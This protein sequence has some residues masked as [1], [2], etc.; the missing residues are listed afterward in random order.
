MN[1]H[2]SKKGFSIVE[3]LTV[4][5]VI[6]ILM[7]LLVPAL[8]KVREF[9]LNTKQ[10]AQFHSL[11]VALNMFQSEEEDYPDSYNVTNAGISG[12]Q[13]LAEAMV[14]RDQQGYDP[15]S[16]WDPAVDA[17]D[18]DIYNSGVNSSSLARRKGPYVSFDKGGAFRLDELYGTGNYGSLYSGT[19]ANPAPVL[20]DSFTNKKI[21]IYDSTGATVLDVVKV[22][23]PILYFKANRSATIFPGPIRGISDYSATACRNYFY[24]I[25]DNV[26]FFGLGTVSDPGDTG[27]HF[28]DGDQAFYQ[29]IRNPM[30]TTND[31]PYNMDT[32]ILLSAG[33]D[34]YY[35]TADDI[36]NFGD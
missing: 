16:S 27:K 33:M 10:K 5:S 19:Q 15:K 24:N 14:G 22:G 17:A 2:T 13:M 28:P 11:S 29:E 34:G 1:K 20:T 4:M 21:N 3:L 7:G 18:A 32:F 12:A 31:R 36:W 23:S 30:I 9:A 35:G 6:A 8:Q 26:Q 25:H